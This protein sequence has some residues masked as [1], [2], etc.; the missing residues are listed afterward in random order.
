MIN[1]VGDDG[2][3][4]VAAVGVGGAGSEV[5]GVVGN[6]VGLAD[7]GGGVDAGTGR[8]PG[9]WV[10]VG[11]G[12]VTGASRDLLAAGVG[13]GCHDRDVAGAGGA[14]HAGEGGEGAIRLPGEWAGEALEQVTS[15]DRSAPVAAPCQQRVNARATRGWQRGSDPHTARQ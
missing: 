2:A 7:G 10:P 15:S 8:P 14:G 13:L 12:L 5:T 4:L 11:A 9:G 3:W 1:P 6:G